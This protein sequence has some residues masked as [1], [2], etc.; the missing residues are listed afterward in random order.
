MSWMFYYAVVGATVWWWVF[1]HTVS[2]KYPDADRFMVL[3][4]RASLLL[5]CIQLWPIVLVFFIWQSARNLA[6]RDE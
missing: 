1:G 6:K 4:A 3:L 5:F 2:N